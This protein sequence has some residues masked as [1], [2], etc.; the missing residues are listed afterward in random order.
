ML[1]YENSPLMR[2]M[3]DAFCA[4]EKSTGFS[5]VVGLAMSACE[6]GWWASTTGDFNYFGI[7]AEP[8]KGPAKFCWTH[9][10]IA[11]AQLQAFRQD[12]RIT[13]TAE[14]DAT[15]KVIQLSG[16]RLRYRMQRWFASYASVE[17]ALTH[18]VNFFIQSPARYKAAWE[19]FQQSHETDALL[20]AICEAGYAT[21]SAETTELAIEHQ[22]NVVSAIASARSVNV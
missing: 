9:E 2:Q 20:K 19:S 13:A 14:T 12:E 3:A 18:Y 1:T 7:T 10:D 6:S 21:G 4:I 15:G 8:E 17:D 5:A 22:G 11:P 16:G